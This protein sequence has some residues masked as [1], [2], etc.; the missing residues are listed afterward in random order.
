MMVMAKD[1]IEHHLEHIESIKTKI[2]FFSTSLKKE[3]IK[4]YQLM[5]KIPEL[6]EIVYH[7]KMLE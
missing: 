5:N 1:Y 7:E 3:K 4:Y 6:Y 2:D